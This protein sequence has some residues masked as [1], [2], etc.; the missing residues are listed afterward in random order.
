VKAGDTCF[1][2]GDKRFEVYKGLIAHCAPV[3]REMADYQQLSGECDI[4]IDHV[5]PAN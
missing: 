5:E 1:V 2:V 4:P 3:L